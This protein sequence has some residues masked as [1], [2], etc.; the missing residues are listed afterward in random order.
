[1]GWTGPIKVGPWTNKLRPDLAHVFFSE[2]GSAYRTHGSIIY[3]KTFSKNSL[4]CQANPSV[5]AG[6]G[7]KALEI[8][9]TWKQYSG[10]NVS[11]FFLWRPTNFLLFSGRKT[12]GSHR[13]IQ[14]DPF[15]NTASMSQRFSVDSCVFLYGYNRNSAE[16]IEFPAGS[17][18]IRDQE[19]STW[20][21]V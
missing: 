4:I 20:I 16:I 5:Q 8:T 13:K 18:G 1:M 9:G 10:Q 11:G 21:F 15:R 12:A 14:K 3:S 19:S 7:S 2:T 17:N 6:F